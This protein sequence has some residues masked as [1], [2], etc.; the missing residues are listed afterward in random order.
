MNLSVKKTTLAECK[1]LILNKHYAKRSPCVSFAYGLYFG[2]ELLGCCTFGKP[3]SYTLCDGVCGKA[4]SKIVWELNRLVL[5]SNEKNH[6]SFLVS[7]SIRLMPKPSVIVSFADTAAGHVGTVYQA[8]NFIYTGVSPAQKYYKLKTTEES[9][10]YRRR[11]RMAKSRIISEYGP[12][13][14]EEYFSTPKHRYVYI[15]ASGGVKKQLL[16]ALRYTQRPYPKR[17]ENFSGE[18]LAGGSFPFIP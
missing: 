6:A 5:Y 1:D 7:G 12:E 13:F 8:S 9:G 10:G 4:Y 15:H 3:A 14:V 11:A 2:D 17:Q 18:N 16:S